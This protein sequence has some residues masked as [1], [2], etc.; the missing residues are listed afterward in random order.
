MIKI[1]DVITE[2]NGEEMQYG[3]LVAFLNSP[4]NCKRGFKKWCNFN[5]SFIRGNKKLTKE[6]SIKDHFTRIYDNNYV[7]FGDPLFAENQSD[8]SIDLALKKLRFTENF[9][10]DNLDEFFELLPPLPET[11]FEISHPAELLEYNKTKTFLGKKASDYSFQLALYEGDGA[12]YVKHLDAHRISKIER[13][14]TII[15][16]LND[17]NNG[18]NLRL[19]HYDDNNN[20]NHKEIEYQNNNKEEYSKDVILTGTQ[21]SVEN[22]DLSSKRRRRRLLSLDGGINK[23]GC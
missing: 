10:V 22:T 18:G 7:G 3:H 5:V 17:C 15:I 14:L 11:E 21:Y 13:K 1:N 9:E 12:H 6:I 19:Y 16:Y 23:V 4:S 2:I 8:T 20:N